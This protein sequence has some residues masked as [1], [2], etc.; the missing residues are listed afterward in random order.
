MRFADKYALQVS[1][2]STGL[3]SS[4]RSAGNGTIYINLCEMKKMAVNINDHESKTNKSITTQTGNTFK[5]IY[6][7]VY[8]HLLFL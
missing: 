5:E 4:G 7:E 3:D 8:I 6:K 2:A 1:V